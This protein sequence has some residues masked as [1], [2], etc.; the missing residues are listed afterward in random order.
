MA[1]PADY[2]DADDLKDVAAGGAIHEDV[3][4]EI[5]DCSEVPTPFLDMIGTDTHDN[6]YS[7]WLEDKRPNA[8]STNKVVSG[9]DSTSAG[10]DATLANQLRVGNHS[11]ISTK[12]IQITERGNA[13]DA[14]GRGEEMGYQTAQRMQDLRYDVECACLSNNASVED[15]GDAVAGQSAGAAAWIKTNDSFGVGGASGGFVTATKLVSAATVGEDRALTWEMIADQIEAVYLLGGVPTTVMSV[16]QITKRLARYLFSTPY[17]ATPTANVNGTG[18]GDAQTSQGYI[19]TFRTDFGTVMKITPN[20]L[21]ETYASGDGVPTQVCNVFGI[22]PRFW[23]LSTIYG[24]KVDALGKKGLSH[25]KL[26]HVDW[27]LKCLLE[28]ANFVI[29]D[30]T[31]T[32]AVTTP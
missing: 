5:F 27:M 2:L 23:R 20:R 12:D 22:D 8:A 11:Q 29:R 24:W 15:T 9:T 25:W 6:P 21:M 14:I 26:A 4:N 10:N 30:I 19:D 32:T 18:A 31:P 13:V 16:P 3:L 28:R 17:A 1:A 7:S